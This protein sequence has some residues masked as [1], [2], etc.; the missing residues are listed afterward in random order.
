MMP[1]HFFSSFYWKLNA[2]QP[3][4][5]FSSVSLV[6]ILPWNEWLPSKECV[7]NKVMH[8]WKKEPISQCV[9]IDYYAIITI[10]STKNERER[11]VI[12]IFFTWKK[13]VSE[14]VI[15]CSSRFLLGVF[16]SVHG[17]H[18]CSSHFTRDYEALIVKINYAIRHTST[19]THK[20]NSV[21]QF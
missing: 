2:I 3:F 11:N 4:H 6:L 10:H 16:S 12:W 1:S 14:N 17:S 5:V 20:P 19:Q 21:R 15:I 7:R 9:E 8:E 13:C 18:C